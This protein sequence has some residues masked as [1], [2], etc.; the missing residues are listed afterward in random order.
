METDAG[1]AMAPNSLGSPIRLNSISEDASIQS[2]SKLSHYQ[3]NGVPS[4]GRKVA[5]LPKQNG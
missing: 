4:G 3:G 2:G 1:H 5:G